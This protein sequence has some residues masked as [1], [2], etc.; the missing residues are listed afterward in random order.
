MAPLRHVIFFLIPL[1]FFFPPS[2]SATTVLP[3]SLTQLTE[4]ADTIVAGV[5]Q[6]SQAYW[7][8]GRIYTDITIETMEFLKHPTPDRPTVIVV[9]TLGGQ[10]DDMRMEVHGVPRLK[11]D[12]EVILFLKKDDQAYTIFGLYYGLCRIETDPLDATQRVSGPLFRARTTQS[13]NTKA[14]RLNPLPPQGEGLDA[15]FQRVRDL[16]PPSDETRNP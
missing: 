16:L 11:V 9:R 4:K 13:L 7:D 1:L 10:V 3:V 14:L 8:E 5:V 15:F 12:D 6:E 2:L